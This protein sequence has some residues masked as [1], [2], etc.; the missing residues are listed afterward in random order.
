VARIA[1][2]SAAVA[3]LLKTREMLHLMQMFELSPLDAISGRFTEQD[4]VSRAWRSP[5]G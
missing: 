2:E 1:D 4:T 5:E 3:I